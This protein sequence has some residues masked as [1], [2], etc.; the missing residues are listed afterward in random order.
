MKGIAFLPG[1][2]STLLTLGITLPASSQVASDGTTTTTVNSIGNNFTILNGIQRGNNLF[3]SFGEF[4]IPTGSSATFKTKGAIENIIN[5]VTGG[6]ISNIDGLIKANGSANLFLINP[7]G[8]VFGENARLDIGGS[9]LGTTAESIVFE[10][11]FEFSAVNAQSEPL[12]TISVPL[13]LQMGSN[14]GK[15]EVQGSGHKLNRNRNTSFIRDARPVGLQVPSGETL[16]LIGGDIS[17]QGGNLTAEG[18]RIELGSVLESVMV[19]LI[20]TSDGFTTGY[21]SVNKFGDINLSQTASV[22]VSGEGGGNIQLQGRQ[23]SV[24]DESVIIASTLGGRDGG[25]FSVK[26]S[27]SVEI[28]G[29]RSLIDFSFFTGFFSEVEVGATGNAGNINIDT[30]QLSLSGLSRISVITAENG[31]AGNINLKVNNLDIRDLGLISL[32]SFAD[33]NAG[34]LSINAADSVSLND[35]FIVSTV[36]QGGDGGEINIITPQLSLLDFSLITSNTTGNGNPSKINLKVDNLTLRDGSQITTSTAGYADADAG[37]ITVIATESVEISGTGFFSIDVNQSFRR[38]SGLFS[39]SRI[40]STGNGNGGNV[41]IITP[42]L[43]ILEGGILSVSTLGSGNAG[44]I[45]IRA[46]E[47]T[48]A[49]PIVNVDGNVT[50]LL[51]NV[52]TRGSGNG[53]S[54]DIEAK[55]LN[56]YNGGQINASTDG[57]GNAGIIDIRADKIDLSGESSDGLFRSAI[58]SN[59][60]TNFNAGSINLNSNQINVRDGAQIS[61]SSLSGGDAG[62]LNLNS[63][64]I[65]LDN[66]ASLKADVASG[67]QGNINLTS[68]FLLLRNGSNITTDATGTANG[69]NI[70]INSPIIAGFE[71]SDIIANAVRGN[72]GNIDITTSGILGLEFRDELTENSDITANSQ[73]GINGTVEINNV[74]IDTSSTIIELPTSLTDPSQ[75]IA[76]GCSSNTDSSFIATGR[77]GIPQNPN[78]SININPIWSDIRD[79]AAFRQQRNSNTVNNTLLSNKLAIVEATGFMR[80]ANGEISLVAISST[81]GTI[82]QFMTCS[83]TNT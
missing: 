72:G 1:F 63:D 11:G 76:R 19:E 28:I 35:G 46:E 32:D 34:N 45:I 44:N 74:G 36:L 18:G 9:F 8:I 47:I 48:V 41:E 24:L 3:H 14:P 27:E 60:T 49:E 40:L 77:G 81:R 33:G 51:T 39:D 83:G 23:I 26:A 58:T 31:N 64:T 15:I 53:G 82:K 50:G 12:L 65:S 38:V 4:S 7:A 67:E 57:A 73:F 55:R 16:A 52:G 78:I 61:V 68:K 75:K 25:L 22:E 43:E 80:N 37:D 21:D 10:D 66:Q 62:N 6:N 2:I 69:G 54:L 71:D 59:S 20:P 5:R 29:N 70:T 42:K 17:L 30:P 13:G 56:I 79:K